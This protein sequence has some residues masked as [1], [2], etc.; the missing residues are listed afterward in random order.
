[1][2]I[3]A[4]MGMVRFSQD[5]GRGSYFPITPK[6]I[7]PNYNL[8]DYFSSSPRWLVYILVRSDIIINLI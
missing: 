2:W 8:Q 7:D 4:I 6:N 5:S 1:M 3:T